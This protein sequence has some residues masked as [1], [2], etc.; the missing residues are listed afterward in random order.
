MDK[1]LFERLTAEREK[2]IVGFEHDGMA[3]G[4][5]WC[6]RASYLDIHEIM[7]T[8]EAEGWKALSN[9]ECF[10]KDAYLSDVP[11]YHHPDFIRGFVTSVGAFYSGFEMESG[12]N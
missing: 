5:K 12:R 8:D 10:D 11:E 2:A 7:D 1:E 6:E 3:W 4:T 9:L